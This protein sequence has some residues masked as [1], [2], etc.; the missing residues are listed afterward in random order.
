MRVCEC[1]R[2]GLFTHRS[3]HTPKPD[4]GVRSLEAALRSICGLSGWSNR[5]GTGALVFGSS[6]QLTVSPAH[7]YTLFMTC[8]HTD[9]DFVDG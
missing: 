9:D 2:G 4:L 7:S 8:L 5:Q 6:S 3:V 1:R